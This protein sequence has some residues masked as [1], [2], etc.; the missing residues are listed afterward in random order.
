MKIIEFFKY[1]SGRNFDMAIFT[2]AELT[3][4]RDK[5]Y[6]ENGYT[7]G[8]YAT[9]SDWVSNLTDQCSDGECIDMLVDLLDK[10]FIE[11]SITLNEYNM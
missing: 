5:F 8:H 9:A 3:E 2:E 4:E 11:G 10:G 7:R 1:D 6:T